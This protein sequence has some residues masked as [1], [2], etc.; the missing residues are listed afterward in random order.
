M[1]DNNLFLT[2]DEIHRTIVSSSEIGQSLLEL[3]K[4]FFPN[5]SVLDCFFV[6][7]AIGRSLY[8]KNARLAQFPATMALGNNSD[9]CF[10]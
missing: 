10:Q 2:N 3:S 8:R 1:R 6:P 5:A 9:G 7:V 4:D